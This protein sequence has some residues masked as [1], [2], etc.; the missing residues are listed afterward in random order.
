MK[1]L[2]SLLA[3]GIILLAISCGKEDNDEPA[4]PVDPIVV[5][6]VNTRN[7]SFS[8]PTY[9]D[10]YSP[11]SS[12]STRAQWNLSNV[13][14]PSVEKCG[15]YFYMYQTDASYGNAH[16]GNGHYPYRRS[17]DLVTN[18]IVGTD[19]NK[20]W[21]ERAFIGLA[22]SDDLS[23]NLWTDKGMVVCSEPDKWHG[24]GSFYWAVDTRQ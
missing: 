23:T 1:H 18:P 19:S 21:T 17:K 2:N 10:N 14:D 9:A 12:W 20:S 8:G 11:V 22:E 4:D 24:S 7:D 16:N 15:E 5:P 3:F 13:H 6:V